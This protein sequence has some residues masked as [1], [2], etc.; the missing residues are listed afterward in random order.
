MLKEYHGL[1]FQEIADL[2]G[3]PLSTVKT[4]LYQGLSVLRRQLEAS[5][6]T[7]GTLEPRDERE[8]IMSETFHCDDKETLVAYLYGEIDA[9]GRR[10]VE[11]HLRTC[12]ACARG[13]RRPA[14]ACGRISASWLPPEPDLGFVDH[15]EAG[16][17]A[18]TE[19]VG[20]ALGTL[21]AVGAGGG[22]G[23]RVCRRRGD[24]QRAGAVTATTDCVSDGLD[25]TCGRGAAAARRPVCRASRRVTRLAAGA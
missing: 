20:L 4:R 16:D 15:A 5:G 11:R 2:Q 1:T 6:M 3:C 18:A 25:D 7:R 22:G 12:A 24:R 21:P 9:D 23:A 19:P 10:E 8:G 14:G 17:G 13:N